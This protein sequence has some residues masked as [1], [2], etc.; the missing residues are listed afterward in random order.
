MRKSRIVQI[1]SAGI[2]L[3]MTGCVVAPGGFRTVPL[4]QEVTF[5][6]PWLLN[7]SSSPYRS[8]YVEVDAVQGAEP[9]QEWL[10]G[11]EHFLKTEC[12]KPGG[13]RVVR[14]NT[15]TSREAAGASTGALALKYLD[16][17]PPGSAFLYVLYYNSS[18]NPALKTANP[19]AVVFPY[20][21]A[22]FVDRNYN[23]AGFGDVLGGLILKH[24]A[25]HLAGAARSHSHGD[26]AH[27]RNRNC[28]MNPSF[29]YVPEMIA[30]GRVPTPQTDFCKDC[31]ADMALWRTTPTPSNLRFNGP[32]LTR[33][34]NGYTVL[35][36]PNTV[37][38]HLGQGMIPLS[39]LRDA[40][41]QAGTGLLRSKEGFIL[42]A[43]SAGTREQVL[44]S[45]RL[46]GSDPASP[47]RQAARLYV[48]RMMPPGPMP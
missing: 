24:E 45:A 7:S 8:L 26:G 35:T 11:M 40:M 30:Q 10:E 34:E 6:Q 22:I 23:Q 13:V 1:I 5:L 39:Q 4:P 17:P 43:S 29:T 28:L 2:A 42:S 14:S 16:G 33:K 27:C 44:E 25:A 31:L 15:I 36:L 12:D 37:H 32:F 47:V 3:L 48:E 41:R 20:P 18:L 9:P 19:H 38:V 46:A 21:C